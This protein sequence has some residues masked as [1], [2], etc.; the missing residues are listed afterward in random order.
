MK[1]VLYHTYGSPDVLRLEEVAKPVPNDDEVLIKIHA[2]SA[3]PLDWHFM[4]GEPFLARL[5]GGLLRPKNPRLG[6]DVAGRV[7]AAGHNIKEFQP[8]DAVFG[9]LFTYGLGAFAEYVCARER[10]VALKPANLSFAEAAS[11]PVVGYTALK[12]LCDT[13]KIQAG[14]KVLING[15]SGGVG[16]FAVQL[17]KAYGA[18]VTGV[19]STRNLEMVRAL[20]ADQVIDYTRED[21]TKS[22]Q[23]Y[24]LIFD[25]VANHSVADY[26][27]ALT[28][29]GRCVVVG[30]ST[31]L[32]LIELSTVGAWVSRGAGQKVGMAG[33][34]APNKQDL[35]TIKELLE[36]GKVVPVIDRRYPLHEVP[37]A[38][39][40]LETGRA[41]GKVVITMGPDQPI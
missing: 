27:R 19:C 14:Q 3:N 31:M 5:A 21:F 25:A 37:E 11:T 15:A 10:D 6:A 12:S 1:A 38:I 40:Y 23:R 2:A 29:Q 24:D 7:E 30:F 9:E 32:R 28:P 41:Q 17:A 34:A 35:L 39:R 16:T 13:G 4:R 22:G 20:G 33:T 8:G 26:Q 18:E 36:T